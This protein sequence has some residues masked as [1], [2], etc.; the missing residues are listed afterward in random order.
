MWESWLLTLKAEQEVI[1]NVFSKKKN[2]LCDTKYNMHIKSPTCFGTQVTPSGSY[3]KKANLL[4]YVLF[5]V[6]R[7]IKALVVKIHKM[8][9]IYEIYNV[10][11]LLCFDNALI[12]SDLGCCQ[13]LVSVF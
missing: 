10:D 8:Y 9:K 5:P 2:V 3:Y 7:L 13:H 6:I 1:I 11:N 4:I 12:I